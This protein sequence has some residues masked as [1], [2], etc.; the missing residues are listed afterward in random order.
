MYSVNVIFIWKYY[1]NLYYTVVIFLFLK[2]WI[3]TIIFFSPY[4][5]NYWFYILFLLIK[6]KWYFLKRT[7]LLNIGELV[8]KWRKHDDLTIL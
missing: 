4:K 8:F 2:R 7:I 1:N 3:Y 5:W 6:V